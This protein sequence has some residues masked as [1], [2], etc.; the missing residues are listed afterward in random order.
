MCV[1]AEDMRGA[2]GLVGSGSG[3]IL[4]LGPLGGVDLFLGRPWAPGGW[5]ALREPGSWEVNM[6]RV[7]AILSWWR[8][9]APARDPKD[10]AL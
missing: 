10:A 3:F 4:S 9:G 7:R 8:G 2:W 5:W 6:G 1:T